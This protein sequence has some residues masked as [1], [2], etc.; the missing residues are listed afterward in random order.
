LICSLEKSSDFIGKRESNHREPVAAVK[1]GNID[2][3]DR[4]I[5]FQI[6]GLLN[7][8]IGDMAETFGPSGEPGAGLVIQLQPLGPL[9]NRTAV[10]KSTRPPRCSA[11]PLMTLRL[12]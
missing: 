4:G 10:T 11:L 5:V 12:S 1:V 8:H 2:P 3:C 9:R 6:G 7:A